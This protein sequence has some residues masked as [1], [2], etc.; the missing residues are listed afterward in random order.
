MTP[1]HRRTGFSMSHIF[2]S[3]CHDNMKEAKQLHDDLVEAGFEV[4]WDQDILAGFA[5]RVDDKDGRLEGGRQVAAIKVL[6]IA[7]SY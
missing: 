1:L 5:T 2:L 7:L 4:R 3:Y 6:S